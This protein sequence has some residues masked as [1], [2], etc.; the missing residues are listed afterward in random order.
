MNARTFGIALLAGAAAL[1]G[2]I[3]ASAAPVVYDG[4]LFRGL[5]RAGS[6]P[7]GDGWINNRGSEVDYWFFLAAMGDMVTIRVHPLDPRLDPAF[8]LSRHDYSRHIA[9]PQLR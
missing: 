8:F 1:L 9:V 3:G 6:V 5:T 7:T 2:S 4:A